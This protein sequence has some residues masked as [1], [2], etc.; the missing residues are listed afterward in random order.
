[1]KIIQDERL[2]ECNY[3]DFNGQLEDFKGNKMENFIDQPF[4][5][6]ESY[7]AVEKRMAGFLEFLKKNYN[8]QHIAIVAHQAPQLALEVL[9]K[10]KTWVQAIQED[11]RNQKVWQPGWD[12]EILDD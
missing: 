7:Q 1:Y 2:R 9:L 10:G 4:P 3:G 6:G 5:N 12:Y 11:W 8:G